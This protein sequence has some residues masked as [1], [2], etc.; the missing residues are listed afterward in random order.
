MPAD[1]PV[2][3]GLGRRA[4]YSPIYYSSAAAAAAEQNYYGRQVTIESGAYLA[5]E[6]VMQ[7]SQ[8]FVDGSGGGRSGYGGVEQ[9]RELARL[10]AEAEAAMRAALA[11]EAVGGLPDGVELLGGPHAEVEY[12]LAVVLAT[13]AAEYR[14]EHLA[15]AVLKGE[16][17]EVLK[18]EFRTVDPREAEAARAAYL[19]A[20][21]E[22]EAARALKAGYEA[23]RLG[24]RSIRIGYRTNR[25]APLLD[26]ETSHLGWTPGAAPFAASRVRYPNSWYLPRESDDEMVARDPRWRQENYTYD[27]EGNRAVVKAL[28]EVDWREEQ[29]LGWYT[30]GHAALGND[31]VEFKRRED[32]EFAYRATY[33]RARA[34]AEKEAAEVVPLAEAVA[35]LRFLEEVLALRSQR[36][37]GE[38]R[39]ARARY[40]GSC[41]RRRRRRGSRC[42]S[43]W[44]RPRRRRRH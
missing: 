4:D 28:R 25:G 41:A 18:G 7:R 11:A 13:R 44:R 2:G 1:G 9:A 38:E 17:V 42:R 32:Y 40:D 37:A 15:L 33:A 36:A 12:F 5:A 29:P 20:E 6:S 31:F 8:Y 34:A 30:L 10:A 27:A 19:A 39:E 22:A 21:A 26:W 35:P 16:G 24:G 3:F 23:A 14:S 43:R